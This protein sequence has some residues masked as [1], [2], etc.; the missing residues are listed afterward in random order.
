MFY[1]AKTPPPREAK[2][3]WKRKAIKKMKKS[4]K[5]W[6]N[7]EKVEKSWKKQLTESGSSD[8]LNKKWNW[9]MHEIMQ[10]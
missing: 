7:F 6:K 1:A 9:L 3:A 2:E 8:I 4:R 10:I 5:Y